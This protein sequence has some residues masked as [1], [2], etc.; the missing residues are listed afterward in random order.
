MGLFGNETARPLRPENKLKS[1]RN[2]LVLTHI[3]EISKIDPG[4]RH[5]GES[6]ANKMDPEVVLW[7]SGV[8]KDW[9]T[10][11][12]NPHYFQQIVVFGRFRLRRQ[13]KRKLGFENQSDRPDLEIKSNRFA[14]C[15][16]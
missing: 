2:L 12:R 15:Q 13:A 6:R 11:A 10:E 7:P 5:P 9:G 1:S 14:I 8:S 16:Y 4:A 3:Y